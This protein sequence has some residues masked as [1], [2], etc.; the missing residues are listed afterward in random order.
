L[1]RMCS[2]FS[3]NETLVPCLRL[4]V[5]VSTGC[6]NRLFDELLTTYKIRRS[7]KIVSR[8]ET[9]ILTVLPLE[10]YFKCRYHSGQCS[11]FERTGVYMKTMCRFLFVC[12]AMF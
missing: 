11:F 2:S 1:H 9:Q 10:R 12:L 7:M 3:S 5:M 4:A 8:C 6:E